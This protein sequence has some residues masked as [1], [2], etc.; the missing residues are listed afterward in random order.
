MS[1]AGVGKGR[2]PAWVSGGLPACV[3][4]GCGVGEGRLPPGVP[5]V[6]LGGAGLQH[7]VVRSATDT[8]VH[9]ALR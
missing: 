5:V 2:L 4:S 6:A 3:K 8:S 9:M 1:C 7:G